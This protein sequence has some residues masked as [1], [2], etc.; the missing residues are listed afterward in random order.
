[1]FRRQI[2]ETKKRTVVP[3]SDP[4]STG[5][6]LAVKLIQLRRSFEGTSELCYLHAEL[7]VRLRRGIDPSTNW[8]RLQGIWETEPDFLCTN[9]NSRWLISAL[10]TFADYGDPV[11][12]ARALIQVAFFNTLRIAQTERI[13]LAEQPPSGNLPVQNEMHELW[14]GIETYNFRRGDVV[15]NMVARI[16]RALEPDPILSKIFETLLERA[17][18][19]DTLIGRVARAS[20]HPRREVIKPG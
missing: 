7:I 18:R 8:E 16:R 20:E 6:P 4:A 3:L 13:L 19:R 12:Q 10:D 11:M 17:L 2:E 1:M 14:D 9:L 5:S 15:W